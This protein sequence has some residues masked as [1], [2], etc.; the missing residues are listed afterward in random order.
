[1]LMLALL[2]AGMTPERANELYQ[3]KD[4][5]QAAAAYAELARQQPKSPMFAFR[6]GASLLGMGRGDEALPLFEQAGKLGFPPPL[7]QAW[8]ARAHV[9]MGRLDAAVEALK[10]ASTRGFANVGLLDTEADFEALRRDARF[11]ALREAVDRN[12]RPC[13]YAPE[14]RQFDF[15][16]G[17]WNVT[18]AGAPAGES[19]VEKILNE[20][21]IWENWTGTSGVSGK[22]FNAWDSTQNE[23]RQSYYDSTGTVSEYHGRFANK[24]MVLVAD[25][26]LPGSDGKLQPTKLRMTFFDMDGTVRQLGENST[27]GGATWQTAY[28]L[29]YTR[30]PA[31]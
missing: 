7:M 23:W 5:A 22:S 12:A 25:G 31:K 2:L 24:K 28:D 1:M 29:L 8:S 14:F 21:V 18:S 6:Q 16:I 20:C 19:H 3:A 30:K 26:L 11:A 4:Y 10:R 13:V 9:K 15:W 27:D 17:D